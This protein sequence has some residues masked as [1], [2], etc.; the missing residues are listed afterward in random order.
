M[1]KD[2][3]IFLSLAALFVFAALVLLLD[4]FCVPFC[5]WFAAK[6]EV[7]S[8]NVP[9]YRV[10][11][12]VT[13]YLLSVPAYIAMYWLHNLLRSLQSGDMFT[14]KNMRCLRYTCWCLTAAFAILMLSAIY[15]MPFMIVALACGFMALIVHIVKNVFEKA[16]DMKDELDFTV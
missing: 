1:K 6:S 9:L 13:V 12:S 16:I 7:L 2:R 10:L 15:Y 5:G 8:D 4:V 14:S 3:S 11:L